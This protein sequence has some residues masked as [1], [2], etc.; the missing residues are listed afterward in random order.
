MNKAFYSATDMVFFMLMLDLLIFPYLQFLIIP[1]G[2]IVIALLPLFQNITVI[3]DRYVWLFLAIFFSVIFSTLLSNFRPFSHLFILDNIK[4]ALQFITLF[5]YFFIFRWYAN[6][7]MK[8]KKTIVAA[9][10]IFCFWYVFLAIIYFKNPHETVN[11]IKLIYGRTTINIE[12]FAF[13]L[14]FPYIFQ[15]ANTSIYFFLMAIGF[16]YVLRPSIINFYVF[17]VLGSFCT[18]LSQ[19]TGGALSWLIM[20]AMMIADR[21]KFSFQSLFILSIVIGI[22]FA[23]SY[24]LL[25]YLFVDDLKIY[26][27]MAFERITDEE[28]ISSGGG[29]LHY[30][31]NLFEMYPL[32]LGRGYM[33]YENNSIILPHSDFFGLIYRYGLIALIATLFF[34]FCNI[35]RIIFILPAAIIPFLVNSLI[36][37]S[38][39]F[40]LYLAFL[41]LSSFLSKDVQDKTLA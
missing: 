29:R 3:K 16:L 8:N 1:A 38:K 19:S 34:L 20:L 39:L 27:E 24:S 32:P 7:K 31:R 22:F 14:R 23:L 28:R 13:D 17:I 41:G 6:N 25:N 35:R 36:D 33:L 15:D 12:D 2:L 37:E 18:L 21:F 11:L 9:L 30:W 10:Y 40:A 4:Y 5:A 26:Y